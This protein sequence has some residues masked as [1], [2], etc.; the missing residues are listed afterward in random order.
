MNLPL[1]NMRSPLVDKD[2]RILAPWNSFFQQLTQQPEAISNIVVGPSP[3]LFTAN[4]VGQVFI[5]GGTVSL[6]QFIRGTTI[7][8]MLLVREILVSI[9][10]TIRITYSVLPTIQFVEL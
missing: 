10:D 7:I 6:V 2:G 8:D 4:N 3:F 1:P 5:R 9:G